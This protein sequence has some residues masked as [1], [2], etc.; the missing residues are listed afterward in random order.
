MFGNYDED[1]R[2]ARW[3]V[4]NALGE[5]YHDFNHLNYYVRGD[6]YRCLQVLEACYQG[7]QDEKRYRFNAL[8]SLTMSESEA[9]LG[10]GWEPP[11]FV[12]TGA[13]LLDL[14]LVNEPLRWLSDPKYTAVYTPFEKGLGHFLESPKKPQL[15]QDVI[16]DMYESVEALS[17][18]TTGRSHRDLSANAELFVTQLRLRLNTRLFLKTISCMQTNSVMLQLT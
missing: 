2:S 5:E 17:K 15:L 18:I 11:I 3:R 4:A 10:I 1:H 8:L 13:M 6:F 9:D 12:R 16:T 14:H 7:L